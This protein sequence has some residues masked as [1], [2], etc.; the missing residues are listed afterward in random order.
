MKHAG[1]GFEPEWL[2]KAVTGFRQFSIRGI[3]VV[4]MIYGMARRKG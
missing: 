2:D 1:G 3:D 4:L